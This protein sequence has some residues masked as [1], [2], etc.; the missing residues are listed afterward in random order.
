MQF[1]NMQILP[2][3]PRTL[4]NAQMYTINEIIKNKTKNTSSKSRPPTSTNSDT[5][6]IIYIK[7]PLTNAGIAVDFSGQLQDNKRI[8]FG[9]VDIDRLR[10]RL[11]DDRGYIVNLNGA[12]WSCSII[13][14]TLYQY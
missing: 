1:S 5:F 12:D 7:F 10:I 6:A 4:T 14:E 3:A 2:S 11:V 13:C 9:P 8:Y